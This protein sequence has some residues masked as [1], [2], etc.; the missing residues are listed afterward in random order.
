MFVVEKTEDCVALRAE[1][2]KHFPTK[3]PGQLIMR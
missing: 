1:L 2:A 3:D